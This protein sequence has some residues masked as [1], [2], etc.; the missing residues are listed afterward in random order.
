VGRVLKILKVQPLYDSYILLICIL[1]KAS[2][3]YP[4][5][6]Q[7]FTSLAAIAKEDRKPKCNSADELIIRIWS[8]AKQ[9]I[10][11]SWKEKINLQINGLI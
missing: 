5:F 9:V 3:S 11:F 4:Y 8:Y 10:V 1:P 7:P 6:F 2:L